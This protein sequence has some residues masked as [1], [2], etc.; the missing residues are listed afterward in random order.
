MREGEKGTR[1]DHGARREGERE[2]EKQSV[3]VNTANG[4]LAKV[5]TKVATKHCVC[6]A[7]LCVCRP[8]WGVGRGLWA[9]R[10]HAEAG[11]GLLLAHCSWLQKIIGANPLILQKE[12]TGPE[13]GS[14]GP[15]VTGTF[16][17]KSSGSTKWDLESKDLA[18]NFSCATCC[19]WSEHS[20]HLSPVF[21]L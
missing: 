19:G 14:D 11:C 8:L 17:G 2:Q 9:C 13:R 3:S 10:G 4:D 1:E 16:T 20:T 18:L 15:T 21:H 7:E 6:F 5:F 12:E